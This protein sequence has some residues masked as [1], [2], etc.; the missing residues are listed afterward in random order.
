MGSGIQNL[1]LNS[2]Y[3]LT[4]KLVTLSKLLK[5]GFLIYNIKHLPHVV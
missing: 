4:Y 2:K 5:L 3:F 1:D